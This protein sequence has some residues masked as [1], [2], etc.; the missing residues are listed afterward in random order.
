M[1]ASQPL[2]KYEQESASSAQ[3]IILSIRGI[4]LR[5]GGIVA[6]EDV[7]FD[8]PRGVICGLIG[9][10]GAGKTAF[11][12]CIS[13]L[14]RPNS[15]SIIYEGTNLLDLPKYRIAELGIGR[16]FQNLALFPTMSVRRNI[17]VG[18]HSHTRG[19]FLSD[20]FRLP[21]AS[22]EERQLDG[23]AQRL[24]KELELEDVAENI[25]SDLPFG[26]KKR[27]ELARALAGQPKL[28]ILDEP[29]G[30]LNHE[31]VS[32]LR[33]VILHIRDEYKITILLVEHHM[34]LV[35][36][37]SDKVVVLNFGKKIADGLPDE[38]CRNSEVICAYLGAEK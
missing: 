33:E 22:K 34:S 37:V 3:E 17:M 18:G 23:I 15:G 1:G 14:Y 8:V 24:M 13:G 6:L 16:T 31:E 38:V 27:V 5:F 12:N 30:G 20:A 36:K 2:S 28:L 4:T 25:V 21:L 9:P 29:A 35:M 32:R 11:F 26:T 7:T 10:N 19:G